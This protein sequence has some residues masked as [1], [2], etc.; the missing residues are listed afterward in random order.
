LSAESGAEGREEYARLL[1]EERVRSAI[2]SALESYGR[3]L[4]RRGMPY[5]KGYPSV[6]N[7]EVKKQTRYFEDVVRPVHLSIAE[8][9]FWPQGASFFYYL[10]REDDGGARYEALGLRL[11]IE[12]PGTMFQ[13]FAVP[14]LDLCYGRFTPDEDDA[15]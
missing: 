11:Q 6:P 5:G 8:E 13:G 2:R 7:K 4:E 9:G 3:L 10:F 14:I 1:T 15:L 12:T